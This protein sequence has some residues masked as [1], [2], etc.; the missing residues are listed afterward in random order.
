MG[1]VCQSVNPS[2]EVSGII[3]CMHERHTNLAREVVDDLEGFFTRARDTDAP[4]RNCRVLQPPIRRNIKLAEAPS[5][6]QTIFQYEPTSHGATD[7][8]ALAA[9]V[10]DGWNP[11]Q[12]VPDEAE[13]P[14]VETPDTAQPADAPGAQGTP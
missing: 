10:L 9:C 7:Y 4:W 2:L 1:L 5:F 11:P 13:A 12:P 6:G 8:A 14:I 3:L